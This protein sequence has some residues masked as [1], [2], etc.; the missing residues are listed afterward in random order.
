MKQ[1]GRKS[2]AAL[3]VIGA[4]GIETI[5][6]PEPPG[7]LSK[8]EAESWRRIVNAYDATRF[9]PGAEPILA[10]LC[11]HIEAARKLAALIRQAEEAE[12]FD[13]DAWQGLLRA[14]DRE[15]ARIASLATRLRLTP[16]ARYVPHSAGAR[17]QGDGA[18]PW[19]ER[20]VDA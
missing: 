14:Q 11:R 12:E 3:S 19:E 4:G 10:Q 8:R 6:R 2:A 9:D 1:R 15:S 13:V 18:K 17:A 5:R 20:I 7:E 16:Q